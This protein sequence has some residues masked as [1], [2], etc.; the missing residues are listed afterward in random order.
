MPTGSDDAP[1]HFL[2]IELFPGVNEVDVKGHGIAVNE[3]G[4]CAEV[5]DYFRG[6]CEGHGRHEY[7][8]TP[9]ETQRLHC[10]VEG[11]CT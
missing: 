3:Y 5:A 9:G 10:Q 8:L 11:G 4:D 2:R 6:C 7:S 1:D